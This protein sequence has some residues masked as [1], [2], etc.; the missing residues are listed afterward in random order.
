M[1]KKELSDLQVLMGRMGEAYFFKGGLP[2]ELGIEYDVETEADFAMPISTDG[3]TFEPGSPD[4]TEEKITEGR[5]WYTFAEKGDDNISMQVPSLA[6]ELNELFLLKKGDAVQV[7]GY[8]GQGYSM[9]PNKFKGGW[10]FFDKEKTVMV[11]LPQTDNYA[12][13]VGGSG[14]GMGY[15]NVAITTLSNSVG[16]D[17]LIFH[18][19]EN[20]GE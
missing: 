8:D 19:N 11:A 10:V 17:I 13:F 2:E 15:Y 3:V 4:V 14:D 20:Q 16:A 7:K 12:N 5:T 18:K 9:S 1:A 6:Q